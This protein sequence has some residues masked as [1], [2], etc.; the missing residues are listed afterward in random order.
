M[1]IDRDLV[2]RMVHTF[3]NTKWIP[4]CLDEIHLSGIETFFLDQGLLRVHYWIIVGE[5]KILH[6]NL[7]EY[8]KQY[9]EDQINKIID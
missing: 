6:I 3:E 5:M 9:R 2:H 7:S 4:R 8:N 1:E